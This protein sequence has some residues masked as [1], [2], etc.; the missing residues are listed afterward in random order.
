MTHGEQ[1]RS[2]DLQFFRQ[3]HG[4]LSASNAAQQQDDH[5]ARIAKSGQGRPSEGVE[6]RAAGPASILQQRSATLHV[7]RLPSRKRM[8]VR[9]MQAM[10]ME[11]ANQE[12]IGV[13]FAD[14]IGYGGEHHHPT[15]DRIE[16]SPG[17]GHESKARFVD[18]PACAC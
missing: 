9:A 18:T 11:M 6:D 16:G 3:A 12:R 10:G 13:L 17:G 5:S 4:R 8:A 15:H 14:Q 2:A 7:R 1:M